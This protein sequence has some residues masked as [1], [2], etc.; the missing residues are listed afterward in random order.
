[1]SRSF[2]QTCFYLV[3]LILLLSLGIEK[4]SSQPAPKEEG[5]PQIRLENVSFRVRKIESAPSPLKMLEVNVEILNRSQQLT[6]P[7]DSI[8]AVVV[9]K[10]VKFSEGVSAGAFAPP[11]GE[12]MFNSPLPPRTRQMLIIGF[13]IPNEKLESITFEVQIN[14]PD[15]EK[16]TVTWEGE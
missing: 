2:K 16:K 5:S 7:P 14:P 10:E 3:I 15:G 6:A 4:G 1:M 12:I 8:K 11:P 9:P 13:S